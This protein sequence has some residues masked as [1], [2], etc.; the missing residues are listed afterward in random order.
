MGRALRAKHQLK[1]RQPLQ[2]LFLITRDPEAQRILNE[3]D[4]LLL[5][6]LNIKELVLA[7]MRRI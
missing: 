5:D 2:R 4:V 1:I 3:L 6:E 7:K